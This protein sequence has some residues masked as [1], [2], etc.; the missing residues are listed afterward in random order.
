MGG[1]Y[2]AEK[3]GTA[4]EALK[5]HGKKIIAVGL[6][7]LALSSLVGCGTESLFDQSKPATVIGREYDDE[8]TFTTY[9]WVNK[10]MVPITNYEPERYLL[11][12]KQ[13]G[14]QG[15]KQADENGCV[16]E[17]FEVSSDTYEK[18]HKGN[19]IVLHPSD[20]NT[21]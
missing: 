9:M 4:K 21:D 1:S 17:V 18:Y 14:Y 2:T 3:L 11:E 15:E 20:A 6:G 13:C 7:S 10:V 12:L 19:T 5:N 8:D 16:E